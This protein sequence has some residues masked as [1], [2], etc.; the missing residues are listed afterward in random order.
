MSRFGSNDS[1]GHRVR[2][3]APDCYDLCWTVDRYYSGSRQR[4]PTSY[5]RNADE[6]GA[7][8][9]CKKWELE[10]PEKAGAIAVNG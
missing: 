10:L 5:R 9:F 6:K 4:F 8:A 2:Y 3:I 7:L 1:Y